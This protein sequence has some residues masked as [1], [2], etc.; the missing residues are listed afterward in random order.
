MSDVPFSE[1]STVRVSFVVLVCAG[2][3]GFAVRFEGVV[4]D[5]E[6]MKNDTRKLPGIELDVSHI[7]RDVADLKDENTSTQ[8]WKRRHM[9]HWCADTE[10]KNRVAG[11]E[12]ECADP[13]EDVP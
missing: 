3:V 11:T 9:A 5:V 2:I 6:Q 4:A 12:W 7:K 8:A 1:N 13:Y 10:K